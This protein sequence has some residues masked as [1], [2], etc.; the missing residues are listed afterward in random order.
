MA[1]KKNN[2]QA[3]VQR[4]IILQTLETRPTSL[5]QLD[6]RTWNSNRRSAISLIPRRSGLYDMYTDVMDSDGQIIAVWGKRLDAILNAPWEFTDH[7]GKPVDAINQLIDSHGFEALLEEIMSAKLWGA[8][9]AEASFFT[10]SNGMNEMVLFP[11]PKKH[12]RPWLGVIAQN[13]ESDEGINIREGIYLDTVMEFGKENDLGLML[14][15]SLF[16]ILKRGTLSDWAEFIEIFGRGIIDA[17]WDGI[18]EDQKRLLSKAI[19]EMGGGGVIIRPAGTSVD[20]KNSTGT[21]NGALQDTFTSKMDGYISKA[22]LGTTETTESSKGS[23]YAQATIHQDQDEKKNDTDLNYVR[24]YLNSRFIPVLQA[25]GFDTKGGTFVLKSKRKINKDAFDVHSRMR[26]ELSIPIDDDFFYEEYGVRKPDN[27]DELKEEMR[28]ASKPINN[29][30]VDDLNEEN[31]EQQD[32][33]QLAATTSLFKRL[34]RLFHSAP[35]A[36]LTGATCCGNHHMSNLSL[37]AFVSKKIF[38]SIADEVIEKAWHANGKMFFNASLFNY[39]A[40]ALTSAFING[41]RKKKIKLAVIGFEYNYNDPAILTA[42]EANLFR[43][44]GAKTLYEAQQLNMLFRKAKS[45]DEFY[46]QASELLKIHN[47]EWLQTEFNTANAAGES[48]ANYVQLMQQ[49]DTFLYWEYKTVGDDRVR[50]SHRL[51]D[52]IILRFDHPAWQKIFP[53]NG[54]GCRCWIIGRTKEE[55]TKEQLQAAESR[56]KDYLSGGEYKRAAKGGWGINRAVKGLVFTENQHYANDYLDVLSKMDKISFEEYGLKALDNYAV[57]QD[58]KHYTDYSDRQQALKDFLSELKPAGQGKYETIDYH[59]RK[60]LITDKML[61][62]HI[63]DNDDYFD[64]HTFLDRFLEVIQK[65]DEVWLNNHG[66]RTLGNYIYIKQ[67]ENYPIAVV[68]QL[69]NDFSL[70]VNS[71]Y[72]ISDDRLRRALLIYSKK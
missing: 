20:I 28:A 52:G 43:F 33:T 25:A 30:P 23:G 50:D 65:P 58:K 11:I 53:P 44:A 6:V 48:A 14:A 29:Q 69:H 47:R 66:R 71:W 7:T 63:K 5:K 57:A 34:I 16:A 10:N 38:D 55:V 49:T 32:K 59:G 24:R 26:K 37:A 18:D 68:C 46:G 39:T 62:R 64:R 36:T 51:L 31:T 56:V 3:L 35:A 60:L 12:L 27:Y 13:Q 17:Q 70:Q 9:A 15:A 4:P 1:K 61:N 42:F 22:L 19:K 40:E 67:Y 2:R 72:D 8:A 54:W 41:Y 45:F 21:A